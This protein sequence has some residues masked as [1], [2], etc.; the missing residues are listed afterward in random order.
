MAER[1]LITVTTDF[2][3][4]D[5][6]AAAMKGAILRHCPSAEIV[7]ISHQVPSHNILSGAFL[8]AGAAPY[9]PPYTVHLVVVDPGVG[10]DRAIL[11]GQFGEQ[12]Y[13]FPDNGIITFVKESAPLQNLVEVREWGLLNLET[14][15]ATFHG[16]DVFAPLAGYIF[17]GKPISRLGPVPEHYTL[18]D[19]PQPR[20]Q[21]G[22]LAGCVIHVDHFGN[23]ITN[24][25]RKHLLALL[26]G[27]H[28]EEGDVFCQGQH[29]GPVRTTYGDVEPGRPVALLNSL[30]LLELAVNQGRFRDAF[31]VGLGAEV[32]V[33]RTGSTG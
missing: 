13:V 28:P 16:R 9:F 22:E 12:L 26:A 7:D 10:T 19:L 18:L 6:Y 27:A 15:S 8:L 17:S 5:P 11:I 33:R 24:I 4:T 29:V 25:T 2:G 20:E 23:L 3:L 32:T 1:P 31:D 14:L 21:A 30:D